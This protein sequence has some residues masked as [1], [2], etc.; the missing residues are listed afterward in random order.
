LNW[1]VYRVATRSVYDEPWLVAGSYSSLETASG[2]P[3]GGGRS[4]GGTRVPRLA[5][6]VPGAGSQ[7]LLE[8][9]GEPVW[10]IVP[11][12]TAEYVVFMDRS[13]QG[14]ARLKPA[15]GELDIDKRWFSPDD[16]LSLFISA[17]GDKCFA[18]KRE[19]LV[20]AE[21]TGHEDLTGYDE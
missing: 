17:G 1:A 19:I 3:L 21:W 9:H 7:D 15:T 18:W 4:F 20:M 5:R 16:K 8:L 10:E 11:D 14:L 6:I 12:P 2:D 13:R